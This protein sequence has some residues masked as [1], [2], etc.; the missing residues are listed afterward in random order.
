MNFRAYDADRDRDAVLRIM[1]EVGWFGGDNAG[2]AWDCFIQAGRMIVADLDGSPEC[3]VLTYSGTIRYLQDDLP[4]AVVGGVTTSRV[5]RKQRFASRLTAA[6]VARDAAEGALVSGLGMFEQGYYDRLGFGSGNYCLDVSFDPA[7]LTVTAQSRVPRR[8]TKDD[9]EAMHA[10]RLARLRGHG[11]VCSYSPL[12]TRGEVLGDKDAFGLGYFDGPGGELTHFLWMNPRG[13]EHGPYRIKMAIWRTGEQ[14]LELMALLKSIG[15]Q[16]HLVSIHEPQDIQIQDLLRQPIK[17]QNITKGSEYQMAIKAGAFWQIRMLDVPGCLARTHLPCADLRFN[18][19][20]A[21]PIE[22]LLDDD[23]PWRGVAGEYVVT[24][25]EASGAVPGTDASL[26]TLNASVNSFTR[27]WFGIRP[28]SGL[29]I[30][31]D[32]SGPPELIR[33]LDEALRLPTPVLGWDI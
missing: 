13:G 9:W 24:L 31:D 30:T 10:A 6:S 15:D 16:V 28:A 11:A 23:S 25:G 14:F 3:S 21:D 33:A 1:K 32:L 26:P 8:L 29:V 18:L 17:K 2:E 22:S 5:A 12:G 7:D 20:L 4:L 27:L 19:S